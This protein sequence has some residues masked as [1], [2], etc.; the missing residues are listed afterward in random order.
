M[1]R[2]FEHER[3]WVEGQ[4]NDRNTLMIDNRRRPAALVPVLALLAIYACDRAEPSTTPAD[5]DESP[6]IAPAEP[7]RFVQRP[8]SGSFVE[9]SVPSH[10]RLAF[11]GAGGS[12]PLLDGVG[13]SLQREGLFLDDELLVPSGEGV[14]P[15]EAIDRHRIMVLDERM[16]TLA[17]AL[18]QS[19][20]AQGEAWI[21]HANFYLD[22][23]IPVADVVD[24]IYTLGINGFADYQL[25]VAREP[26]DT[27]GGQP[28]GFGLP[29]SPP[30][31][32]R[33]PAGTE[34]EPRP[35]GSFSLDVRLHQ[36]GIHVGKRG[37]EIS[38]TT[39]WI[40]ALAWDAQPLA[41]L[42]ALAGRL[43]AELRRVDPNAVPLA[44]FRAD[45][46]LPIVRMM[47][48][49]VASAGND[50]DVHDILELD[51]GSLDDCSFYYFIVEAGTAAPP[52]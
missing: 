25:A 49:M 4:V 9:A 32:A 10:W 22:P 21:G 14:L 47:E 13:L 15:R 23:E 18:Q 3:R 24:L 48:A 16:K 40:A 52:Q 28:V 7:E 6:S 17:P 30:K 19:A 2:R 29:F 41:E 42:E 11:L 33:L 27:V 1:A 51:G 43:I 36:D 39:E 8:T 44:T 46:A 34:P 50:C 38:A 35:E 45:P 37:T 31:F 20:E 12:I 5:T 26:G